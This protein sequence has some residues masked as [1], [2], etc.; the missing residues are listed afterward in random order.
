V[1]G[2]IRP[3]RQARRQRGKSDTADA[4]AAAL[5]A[6]NGEASGVTP[7]HSTSRRRHIRR[8]LPPAH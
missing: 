8:V 6:L 5:A 7:R 4:V 3:N 1:A 2:V